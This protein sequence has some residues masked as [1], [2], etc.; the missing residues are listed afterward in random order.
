MPHLAICGITNNLF[1]RTNIY[2]YTRPSFNRLIRYI[3]H[4][5]RVLNMAN[6]GLTYQIG[7][8]NTRV[9][10]SALLADRGQMGNDTNG[11]AVYVKHS[12]R[13]TTLRHI[14]SH[15]SFKGITTRTIGIRVSLNYVESFLR[16]LSGTISTNL[17]TN[18]VNMSYSV[19]GSVS[20]HLLTGLLSVGVKFQRVVPPSNYFP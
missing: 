17:L 10:N 2:G 20:V 6:H 19:T 18:F 1:L 8:G 12:P 3:H 11:G 4:I 5:T 15:P 7:M 16:L 14:M 9:T 13:A